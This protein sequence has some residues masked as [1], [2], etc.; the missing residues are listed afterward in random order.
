MK[1]NNFNRIILVWLLLLPVI[2]GLLVTDR[3]AALDVY[4][5]NDYVIPAYSTRYF[6]V[7]PSEGEGMAGWF[8]ITNG[9]GIN[10]FIVDQFGHNDIQSSGTAETPHID[11]DYGISEGQWHYWNFVAPD[12]DTWYVYFSNALN[13]AYAGVG[14]EID[15]LIRTNTEGPSLISMTSLQG[16]LTGAVI[17][18]FEVLDD[19]Y[20]VESVELYIDDVLADTIVNS[21]LDGRYMFEGSFTWTTYNWVNGNYSVYLKAYDTLGKMSE[22]LGFIEVEVSNSWYDNPM[23]IILLGLFGLLLIGVLCIIN[24]VRK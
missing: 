12:T 14:D 19:C 16:P 11:E 3:V 13:T 17:I 7:S 23:N 21:E 10:F 6:A 9:D 4:D 22:Q 15:I 24:E 2:C 1:Q 18:D 5:E 8:R 20:P